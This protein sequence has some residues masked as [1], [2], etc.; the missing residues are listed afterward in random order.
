MRKHR[1]TPGD[2]S[3]DFVLEAA[4]AFRTPWMILFGTL[5]MLA[6]CVALFWGGRFAQTAAWFSIGPVCTALALASSGWKPWLTVARVTGQALTTDGTS[7][8]EQAVA[9]FFKSPRCR[10]IQFGWI[11]SG[12]L[13]PWLIYALSSVAGGT[14][15]LKYSYPIPW[16]AM[17]NLGLVAGGLMRGPAL[18]RLAD[19]LQ[20]NRPQLLRQA[21]TIGN[22]GVA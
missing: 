9:A 20:T 19:L 7:P 21:A 6:F 2:L 5:P 3:P 1:S 11:A 18:W 10:S 16:W 22:S 12:A 14:P 4:L 8:I 15:I 17:L 13:V